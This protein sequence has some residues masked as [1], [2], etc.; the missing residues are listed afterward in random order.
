VRTSIALVS[1]VRKAESTTALV[2]PV[3]VDIGHPAGML[4]AQKDAQLVQDPPD[5]P[6]GCFAGV[7]HRT[8]SIYWLPMLSVIPRRLIARLRGWRPSGSQR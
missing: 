2:W 5:R 8:I 7:L 1:G 6:V 4:V 3:A